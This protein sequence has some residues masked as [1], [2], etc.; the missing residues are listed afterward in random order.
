MTD[1][2]Q[3]SG[4][5]ARHGSFGVSHIFFH[6]SED[7]RGSHNG[8]TTLPDDVNNWLNTPQTCRRSLPHQ[9]MDGRKITCASLPSAVLCDICDA[10]RRQYREPPSF[11]PPSSLSIEIDTQSHTSVLQTTLTSLSL[12]TSTPEQAQRP[13]VPAP[14]QMETLVD[15][16]MQML[17]NDSNKNDLICLEE[18]LI[19]LKEH[20]Y[21]MLCWPK[22]GYDDPK[23]QNHQ[24][25]C[26]EPKFVMSSA[27]YKT[28][29]SKI[30]LPSGCCWYCGV[31][32]VSST[33]T[34]AICCTYT[35]TLLSVKKWVS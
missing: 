34:I 26:V 17:S 29:R 13:M 33:F 15:R 1:Y 21:C 7:D 23:S 31:P 9:L 8:A 4:R 6:G 35:C 24:F 25:S 10:F 32:E 16:K 3:E 12:V 11:P 2:M 18:T 30:K 27:A 20:D 5:A 14:P 19:F 22:Y 28:F